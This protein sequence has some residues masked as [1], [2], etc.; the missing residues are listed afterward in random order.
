[1]LEPDD[2]AYTVYMI[3]HAIKQTKVTEL[4]SLYVLVRKVH[5]LKKNTQN[6]LL[7]KTILTRLAL[8]RIIHSLT[9]IHV[10]KMQNN[11]SHWD[12]SEEN[13]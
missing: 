1:M 6:V 9:S 13:T 10:T 11:F 3:S 7:F 2:L 8:L 5:T 4:I 12:V